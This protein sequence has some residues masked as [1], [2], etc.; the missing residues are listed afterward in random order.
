MTC[1]R[2]VEHVLFFQIYDTATEKPAAT[3]AKRRYQP[4]YDIVWCDILNMLGL[5]YVTA[6]CS[7]SHSYAL[8]I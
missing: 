4:V 3:P 5:R 7:S 1:Q 6:L 2:G 8:S